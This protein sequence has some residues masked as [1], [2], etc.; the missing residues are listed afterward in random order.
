[1][2][3]SR[4]FILLYVENRKSIRLICIAARQPTLS[5]TPRPPF[6]EESAT[7]KVP[8]A[9]DAWNRHEF[10]ENG[11]MAKRYASIN[12]QPINETERKLRWNPA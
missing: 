5:M 7:Q 11:Y 2:D 4:P 8:A 3:D 10:D 6:T 12:D 1:M 9:E